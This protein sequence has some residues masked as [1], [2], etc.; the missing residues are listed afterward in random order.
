MSIAYSCHMCGAARRRLHGLRA[1]V[2]SR[3][4]NARPVRRLA[5]VG[6]DAE[7]R[8][9]VERRKAAEA[10]LSAMDSGAS[11][12]GLDAIDR[13]NWPAAADC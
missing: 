11:D 2:G 13:L 1:A 12:F 9:G 4:R 5:L 6:A 10:L 3:E 8:A 7:M